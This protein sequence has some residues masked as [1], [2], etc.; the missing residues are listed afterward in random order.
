M[1]IPSRDGP[2][3]TALLTDHYE[4]TMLE[5]ALA[6]GLADRRAVFEVFSRRLPAGRRYG[7]LAGVARMVEAVEAFRFGEEELE[8]LG[9]SGVVGQGALER[10]AS[11]RFGGSI[12]TY[13]EGELYFP[14][15]PV[16]TIESTFAEAVV[17]E[18]VVLSI[19]NHDSAVAAAAARM[20]CAARGR[21]LIEMGSRRTHEEAAVAAA[22]AAYLAG[23]S[24][25]SNLEAGRR[26]GVPTM[27]TAS[28]AF[29]L[30]HGSEREAFEAQVEA[31]GPGTTLLVD[32][33]DVAQGI[34]TAIDVAGPEL[35]A[36]RIDSGDLA[37]AARS[38]RAQ[39]DSLGAR[40]TRIVVSGDLDEYGIEELAPEPI[41][42]YGVGT[43][44]VAGSGAPSAS[45]V[46]KLV[47]IADPASGE[48][49][50]VAKLSAGKANRGGRKVAWR[51]LDAAGQATGEVAAV[52]PPPGWPGLPGPS[53]P[54]QV[55]VMEAGRPLGMPTLEESRRHLKAALA[56]LPPVA[57]MIVAGPPALEVTLAPVEELEQMLEATR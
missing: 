50:P 40:D 26:W 10:L 20:V 22:R 53:R 42:A 15:S 5:A 38:A 8:A 56:E 48:M 32:T 33:Y 30:A 57:R 16:V 35:G 13:A 11:Y 27:G 41:D 55:R 49:R 36:I 23:F 7:V 43:K 25:T 24:A 34:A 46:Y 18:T 4:L 1:M 19:L 54:L 2:D 17:L 28:H 9:R 29:V 52:D 44:V 6:S 12:D 3:S 37:S 39:L 14:A 51:R 47:A 45:F 31:Q 21:N